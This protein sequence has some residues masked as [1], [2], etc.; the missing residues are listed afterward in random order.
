MPLLAKVV[1]TIWGTQKSE[2][3]DGSTMPILQPISARGQEI[4]TPFAAVDT[5]GAGPGE[6]VLYVTA[7]EAVIP[8]RRGM[9]PI[10]AA[11]VGIVDRI[12]LAN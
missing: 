4:G 3:L 1:G 6:T 7:Y 11:I 10:D 8:C 9:V 5:V 2:G 12:D